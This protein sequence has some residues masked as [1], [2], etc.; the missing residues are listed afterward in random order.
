[1]S[2]FDQNP[3]LDFKQQ[4]D[5][6]GVTSESIFTKGFNLPGV[7]FGAETSNPNSNPRK[8]PTNVNYLYQTFF[9]FSIQGF[10]KF[11][12]FCQAVTLPGFGPGDAV[13]QATRFSNL[14]IP[15]TKVTFDNLDVTFLVDEDMA[16]WREIQNWMKTI[17]LIEDHKGLEKE[18]SNQ[19]RDGELII[20]NSAMKANHHIKFKN[21]FP[22]SL[23]G[24]E[25]DSS[26]SDLT[27]FTATA[28]FAFDTYDFVDP[29]SGFSL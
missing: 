5:F 25:F 9:R 11:N 6:S 18:F 15:T 4:F 24:L 21:I 14:K 29:E 7:T 3:F 22:V 16:N 27:P 26:V 20:L 28:S 10:D 13:S 12:Y 1:M 23:S 17:Y 19:I 2:E 8:Q